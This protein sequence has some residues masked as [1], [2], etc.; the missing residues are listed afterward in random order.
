[1]NTTSLT[2]SAP[3]ATPTLPLAALALS[4]PKP[5]PQ[6][7]KP[8]IVLNPLLGS[9]DILSDM[10]FAEYQACEMV[11]QSGWPNF[12]EVGLALEQVRVQRLYRNDFD[13]FEAYCRVRWGF[14]HSK[15][16]YQIAAAR[17]VSK[18]SCLTGILK[19]DNES[20]VR[21]LLA[22]PPESAQLAWEHAVTQ[23]GGGKV[24]ADTVKKAIQ[25][26]GLAPKAVAERPVS[27]QNRAE[28]CR[29]I[30]GAMVELLTLIIQRASHETLQQ[31]FEGLQI[32]IQRLFD[33][34]ET[35]PGRKTTE[36]SN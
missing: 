29:A 24:T 12:V 8:D 19:P 32:H 5:Q 35:K 6:S 20:Q 26:L 23:S 36:G 3:A 18:L 9:L 25:K 28:Q 10:E 33:G 34:L 4:N 1:M 22:L 21:P 15:V 30:H 14:Q 13:S 2:E 11:I 27:R 7:E 16:Y 17:V 31:R